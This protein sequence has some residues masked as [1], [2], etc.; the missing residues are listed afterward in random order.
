VQLLK[1]KEDVPAPLGTKQAWKLTHG[2]ATAVEKSRP[3]KRVE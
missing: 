3:A 2:W 1:K